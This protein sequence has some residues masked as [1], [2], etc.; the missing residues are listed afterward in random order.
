MGMVFAISFNVKIIISVTDGGQ[1]H[2][3]S[4]FLTGS[5]PAHPEYIS[6]P[7]MG[8]AVPARLPQGSLPSKWAWGFSPAAHPLC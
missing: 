8:K 4:L 1:L 6:Q 3:E 7:L 5:A 2:K